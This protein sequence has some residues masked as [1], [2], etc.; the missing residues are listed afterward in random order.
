[1]HSLLFILTQVGLPRLAGHGG[2]VS[3]L[4]F[5]P[6]GRTLAS[7]SRT[8]RL[9][10]LASGAETRRLAGHNG[11]VNALAFAP[12]GGTLAS[13]GDDKTGA[14]PDLASGREMP[15]AGRA[16][17][18]GQCPGVRPRRTGHPEPPRATTGPC[19][20]GTSASGSREGPTTGAGHNGPVNALAFEPDGRA[21]PPR[22]T[23]RPCGS[24]TSP[25]GGEIRWLQG[26]EGVV[27]ALAFTPD[28]RTLASAGG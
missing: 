14:P 4:A 8:V 15:T 5:A 23:T 16:Q 12:D 18:P 20:S 1:M 21:W 13:A 3:A 19:G 22:A 25:P 9:W 7:A 27:S 17:R 28:A 24:G 10:D 26:H 6:D 11:P 2:E